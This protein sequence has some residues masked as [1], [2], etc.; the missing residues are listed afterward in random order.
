[1]RPSPSGSGPA[2]GSTELESV[3]ARPYPL[4][5]DGSWSLNAEELEA[6]SSPKTRAVLVVNPGN[7]TGAWLQEHEL[8][9]LVAVCTR[10]QWALIC[11]EVFSA[12]S[13]G[14]GEQRVR[15][16]AGR[17]LDCLTFALGG[18]SKSAA[19]PQLK[20]GWLTVGGP[21][22]LRDESLARL[23]LIADSYLSV[24]GPVQHA[25]PEV[26]RAAPAMQQQLRERVERN[27][28]ALIAARPSSAPW[29]V[30]PSEGGWSALLRIPEQPDEESR[31][32]ELLA[33][34]VRVQPG[35]FYDFPRGSVLVLSL[36]VP[37]DRFDRALPLLVEALAH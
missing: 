9:A 4:Q 5:F 20:L 31:C 29:S 7:P 11:D 28:H 13:R 37:T 6:S 12:D 16:V 3:H 24:N 25:L 22:A 32:L 23:E 18:L 14:T 8:E 33:R 26:L 2:G 30:L 35:F 10:R 1:M 21:K 17:P 19:L 36:L 34:G 27:R 15:S